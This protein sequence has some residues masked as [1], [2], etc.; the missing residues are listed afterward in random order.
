MS[1]RIEN[2][3][4][5]HFIYVEIW[6]FTTMLFDIYLQHCYFV[7]RSSDI[8]LTMG[9][10]WSP[11]STYKYNKWV[12]NLWVTLNTRV[13]KTAAS[14]HLFPTL[15][16]GFGGLFQNPAMKARKRV[17]KIIEARLLEGQ[18]QQLREVHM[19]SLCRSPCSISWRS[20]KSYWLLQMSINPWVHAEDV[21]L[22]FLCVRTD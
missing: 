2:V 3:F 9:H 7:D 22:S 19:F 4:P 13:P 21:L 11:L 6:R 18:P 14:A 12:D 8:S 17:I 1:A 5:A 15:G 10:S 16:F 20:I